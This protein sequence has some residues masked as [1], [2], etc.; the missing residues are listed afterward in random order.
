MGHL[1][2]VNDDDRDHYR[3]NQRLTFTLRHSDKTWRTQP[4]I[5]WCLVYPSLRRREPAIHGLGTT[6]IFARYAETDGCATRFFFAKSN[7]PTRREL[8]QNFNSKSWR[9]R[10]RP[11]QTVAGAIAGMAGLRNADSYTWDLKAQT[12]LH[13]TAQSLLTLAWRTTRM[14]KTF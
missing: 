1:G 6:K 11:N 13:L 7:S 14:P 9:S 3:N 8:G 4:E 2:L 10:I 5:L 12:M